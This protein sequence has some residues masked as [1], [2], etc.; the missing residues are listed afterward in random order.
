MLKAYCVPRTRHRAYH[1]R[2]GEVGRGAIWPW[3]HVHEGPQIDTYNLMLFTNP[4]I[5]LGMAWFFHF[6]YLSYHNLI[7]INIQIISKYLWTSIGHFLSSWPDSADLSWAHS[8]GCD[9]L[10]VIVLSY[11]SGTYAGIAGLVLPHVDSSCSRITC[12]DHV[13]EA[14]SPREQAEACKLSWGLILTVPFIALSHCLSQKNLASSDFTS[15]ETF[16]FLTGEVGKSHCRRVWIWR[17]K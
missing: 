11:M 10:I 13:A 5:L 9:A 17:G 6:I 7:H 16:R 3:P 4:G 12:L 15:R 8:Y 2:V 1:G 14:R